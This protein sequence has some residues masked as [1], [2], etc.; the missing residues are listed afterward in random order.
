[1]KRYV[2]FPTVTLFTQNDF[3]TYIYLEISAEHALLM[4]LFQ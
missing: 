4:D 1:M 3:A 2:P